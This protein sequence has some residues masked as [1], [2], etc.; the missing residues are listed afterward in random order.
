MDI[1]LAAEQ[2]VITAAVIK[3]LLWEVRRKTCSLSDPRPAVETLLT[4][5]CLSHLHGPTQQAVNKQHSV[6]RIVRLNR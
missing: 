5:I 1:W 2:V 6:F 3:T 4:F